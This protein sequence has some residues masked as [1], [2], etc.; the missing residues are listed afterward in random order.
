MRKNF[1]PKLPLLLAALLLSCSSLDE[2]RLEQALVFAGSNREELEKVLEHYAGEPEKLSAARFLIMNMPGHTGVDSSCVENMR[3][4]YE[5]HAGISEKHQ[6]ERS[7]EWYREIDSLWRKERFRFQASFSRQ[8]VRT[9]KTAQ[10]IREIDRSLKAW[11]ENAYTRDGS[12]ED[13]C[14]YVLPYRF[15][16]GTCFDQARDTFYR[17]HASI[18]GDNTKDFREVTDSLHRLY[19]GLM[20]NN[21]AAASMPIYNAAS[22]EKVKRGSC[23]DKAWYNCL[24]MSA[25]GMGVAVDFVPEWGNRAG[26]IAGTA[27]S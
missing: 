11:K 18:F 3:P 20:H 17:R 12:F 10:L 21:W 15:A 13:F 5:A 14:R 22:F 16:E 4:L 1:L 26:G 19:S 7:S 2:S 24:M 25:L 6:W 23:D 27:W 8:D 9:V